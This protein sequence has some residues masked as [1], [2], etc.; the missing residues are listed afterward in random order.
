LRYFKK[1]TAVEILR[2]IAKNLKESRHEWQISIYIE[3]LVI[4]M[5]EMKTTRSGG[6]KLASLEITS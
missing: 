4:K 3:M 5:P 2:D 6:K 1:H